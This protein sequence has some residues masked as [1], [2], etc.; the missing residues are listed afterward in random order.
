MDNSGYISW[1]VEL[2]TSQTI[3]IR[4]F[5][6][7]RGSTILA[8]STHTPPP[9]ACLSISAC[10]SSQ[11]IEFLGNVAALYFEYSL[12][13]GL[14]PIDFAFIIIGCA[15]EVDDVVLVVVVIKK[16][17]LRNRQF[18]DVDDK[19]MNGGW[20]RFSF[21]MNLEQRDAPN[22][23]EVWNFIIIDL[24]QFF[25]YCWFNREWT[26]EFQRMYVSRSRGKIFR[27]MGFR[28]DPF[29]CDWIEHRQR[30][31]VILME[32]QV[33]AFD[34]ISFYTCTDFSQITLFETRHRLRGVN[35][36]CERWMKFDVIRY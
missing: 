22:E 29:R 18:C 34:E 15:V 2:I 8:R 26:L 16:G 17:T 7:T 9:I 33:Q 31:R 20:W 6:K 25:P 35:R 27:C 30:K 10:N 14:S 32:E 23:D 19:S 11:S 36:R 24:A 21:S 5:L 3:F 4:E 13:E 28:Q 12:E 1:T